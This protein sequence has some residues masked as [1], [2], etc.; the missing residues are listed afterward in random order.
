MVSGDRENEVKIIIQDRKFDKKS[1]KV[2]CNDY[3]ETD[4]VDM[5][6]ISI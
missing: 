6:K 4:Y 1:I 5:C 2:I 3:I